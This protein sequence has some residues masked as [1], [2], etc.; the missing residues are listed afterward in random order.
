MST[1]ISQTF[2]FFNLNWRIMK[3]VLY[4]VFLIVIPFNLFGC[5]ILPLPSTKILEEKPFQDEQ[6]SSIIVGITSKEEVENLLGAPDAT[7]RNNAVYIF[8]KPYIYG[9]LAIFL[10]EAGSVRTI[11]KHHLLIVQFDKN[12]VVKNVD[13]I[14]GNGNC[15]QNG[16]C[17]A[18]AGLRPKEYFDYLNTNTTIQQMLV[19]YSDNITELNAKKFFA[20]RGK[21]VIYVYREKLHCYSPYRHQKVSVN[22]DGIE[23]GDFGEEGFFHWIVIPGNHSITVTPLW[24]LP[25]GR[26]FPHASI[27]I[28]LKEGQIY[29]IEQT[30]KSKW[31]FLMQ[32]NYIHLDIVSD[33]IK[34]REEVMKRRM[35]LDCI[36]QID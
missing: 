29:F 22:L 11:E 3:Y 7:R 25:E 31:R 8:A 17:V 20:P 1:I 21:S 12:D 36:E 10:F 24:P 28:D 13:H 34:G 27:K 26:W 2:P 32:Y 6:V 33:P 19:L 15:T 35:I 23:L 30:L 4:L 5:L 16:I 18:D 14:V 9:Y